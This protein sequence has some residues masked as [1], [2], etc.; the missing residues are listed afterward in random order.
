MIDKLNYKFNPTIEKS[1]NELVFPSTRRSENYDT[2]KE[3]KEYQEIKEKRQSIKRRIKLV[4]NAWRNGIVG[5]EMPN[6]EGG[7]EES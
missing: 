1:S 5:V 3:I 4:K 7:S 2:K 6:E